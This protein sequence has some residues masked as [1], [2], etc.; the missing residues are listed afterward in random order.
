MKKGIWLS[1]GALVLVGVIV[2][3]IW[4]INEEG[5]MRTGSKDAFIPYNSAVV[6][7]VNEKPELS[8]EV[9]QTW[10][11]EAEL[12]GK[13]LLVR[14][15]DSL[16][17]KDYAMSYPYVLSARVEGK[18]DVA[19]LYVMDH[20]YVLS[21]NEVPD[22]LNRVFAGGAE[23]VR[24]YDQY[25]IYTLQQGKETVYFAVCGG[26]IL[27]SDSDLYVEDALKQ[28]DLEETGEQAKPHY[29][30]LDK[31]FSV[32]A[33]VHIFLNTAFFSDFMP[34]YV[35]TKKIFPHLDLTRLFKWGALDGELASKGVCLNG[36]MQYEG[37]EKSYVRTLKEQQPRA[38]GIDGV[39]PEQVDALGI[40]NLSNPSA[41]LKALDA[42]RYSMDL[43]SKTYERKQQ[44][45]K[46]FGRDCEKEWR[47]L[48]QGEFA[49]AESGYNGATREKN[50]LVVV[51]LKSGSLG[52]ILLDKMMQA[53]ARFE[54]KSA[55]DYVKEHRIDREKTFSYYCCP[56]EDMPTVF[57]GYLFE[58]IKSRYMLIEDNYL[59]FAS[60]E[61]VVKDFIRDYVHG[62]FVRDADW[63]RNLKDKL[64]G[65]GNFTYFARTG[66]MWPQY[67][68]V[69]K[70]KARTFMEEHAGKEPA[71]PTWALQWSNEGGL[72]YHT[73]FLSSAPVQGEVRAHALWQTRLDDRVSMKPVP[74]VNHVTGEREIFVQDD[75]HTVY[76][77]NDAG[78]VLWKVPVD[79]KINS[80]V[81]QV[82]L[83]K[84]GKL[85]YL[86]S[87]SSKMYLIDRNGNA[88]GRF[89]L[90]FRSVCE[91]GITVCD[92]DNNKD[93]RI[94]APCADR[95][96]YLYGLDGNLV[97]GW[98]PEK[99]DKPIVT[100]V[101]HFRVE[102]KD[103]LVFADRYRFYIL[104]RKGKERI[105]VSSV[106][107]LP[108]QADVYM[109]CRQTK[110]C[111]VCAGKCGEVYRIGL[112]GQ[113]RTVK[114]EGLVGDFRMNV[115]DMDGDGTEECVFTTANRL[116]T[117]S[118]DG[119]RTLDK[120]IEAESLDYPYVYRFSAKDSRIGVADSGNSR[121][122]LL[123][124]DGN[125]S[126]GFPI[127]GDS[128]FS[129]VFSGNDG[130][131]LYAGTDS[132]SL[133]KYRVQR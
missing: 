26:I 103:Y 79:G 68:E 8:P 90:A 41:Y 54:G 36:F 39:V 60:S 106:L 50:G 40:L 21:R 38:S 20:K 133:I 28:F 92:Y 49:V 105:R 24:K 121:M 113:L 118:L 126:K 53:Y 23:K 16:R 87:T 11:K 111:W 29:Q 80:E 69:A 71:F 59:I 43:K 128:P 127:A 47:E 89:P 94:F 10:G 30:N 58:R 86:F 17:G 15:T 1:L 64:S 75:R 5:K 35:Q 115:A 100:K 19:L 37:L 2:F 65:K 119:K 77:I 83:F 27:I 6:L 45:G 122:L 14:V 88:A 84:N 67:R 51:A 132:S 70:G 101:R 9:M 95:E 25:K 34:L 48:L 13:R 33:G 99:T 44:Y 55:S 32:G 7:S 97:K 98:K 57:W 117:V 78:R 63:Y 3:A 124:S 108:E 76:L 52:R 12:F 4:Y 125:L 62:S 96:V 42:Y 82:D 109:V 73:L 61:K 85:Q 81:Y 131:Y 129:I 110:P 91:Q 56:V 46:M 104:D 102:G 22:Y 31:Y 74:V 66:K 93:Y 18:G 112:D 107:D 114:V 72:L 116:L 120:V 130:F 123:N